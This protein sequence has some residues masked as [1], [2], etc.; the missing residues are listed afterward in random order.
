VLAHCRDTALTHV[1]GCWVLDTIL[2]DA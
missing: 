1:R 2:W